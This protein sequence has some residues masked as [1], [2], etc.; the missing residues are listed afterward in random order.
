VAIAGEGKLRLNTAGTDKQKG[1]S[2]ET[3]ASHSSS[4]QTVKRTE[5][6]V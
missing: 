5:A 3:P 1:G 2:F 4:V 6:G